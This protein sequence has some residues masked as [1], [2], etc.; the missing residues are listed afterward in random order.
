MGFRVNTAGRVKQSHFSQVPANVAAPRSP[1]DRS[2]SHK[3]TIN[4]GFLYPIFWE[5]ILPGD[6]VNLTMNC[7]ARLATPIFPYMDNVYLD[8]HWF[9]VPNRLVWNHWEQ[10][11][12][13]QDNPPDTF[14]DYEVPSLD[15]ATH[16]GG[17][18]SGS[19]YDYFGLPTLVTGIDQTNMPIA[20]PFRAY[21]KIWNEWYRDENSQDPLTVDMGDGPDTT[22][23]SLLKRNR[24]KDYF[25]SCL[26]W[27]QKGPAVTIP[28]GSGSLPVVLNPDAIPDSPIIRRADNQT[29]SQNSLTGLITSGAGALR[30]SDSFNSV[31]D[32]NDT[33]MVELD[34]VAAVSINTLRESIVLQQMLELDA[35][36]GTRYVEALLARFGVVSPDFRLQRPEF[37]GGQTFDIN[38]SPI[39]QTSSTDAETPQGNLSGFAVARGSSQLS[40]SFVEHGQLLGLVSVRADATYQQGMSRH[41]SVRTRY[42]YYEP[43]AANLGEQAVL[44]KEI[45]MTGTEATDNAV[46]GYQERWAEYRYKPSYV[47]G[48]FRSNAAASLDSWHLA[49]EFGS[50]P[51]LADL[52]PESPPIDRIVAVP[53]EPHFIVDTWTK[54]RHVRVLPVYSAPGLTRL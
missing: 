1:F 2:F 41:W 42:D 47:T 38:V 51:T 22:D 15:D 27:P 30:G 21:R 23:Y 17:F 48:I 18:A 24:R 37:L 19:L 54:F 11:Q 31:I 43:L 40:H 39:A 35:R 10:F 32:P 3:T 20:L 53:S 12:G 6:T 34:D 26:P 25:T 36:G 52:L 29:S 46:F 49:I 5:P 8:V 50:L 9:F 33:L 44:N 7:L 28:I 4:E 14:T 13:A 16:A 45:Y